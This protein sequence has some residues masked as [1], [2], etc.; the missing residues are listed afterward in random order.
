MKLGSGAP[1]RDGRAIYRNG[2]FPGASPADVA[3]TRNAGRQALPYR[4]AMVCRGRDELLAALGRQIGAPALLPE[5]RPQVVFLFPGQGTGS[6]DLG[7][8]LYHSEPAYREAADRCFEIL[9]PL[10]GADPRRVLLHGGAEARR[11][12]ERPA[13]V[14][15]VQYAVLGHDEIAVILLREDAQEEAVGEVTVG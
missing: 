9:T 8:D 5:S 11:E 1:G 4:D 6:E 14:R 7:Q 10:V 12:L 3:F 13:L 15:V 2:P